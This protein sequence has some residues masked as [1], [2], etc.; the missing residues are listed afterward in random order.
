[1]NGAELP[2]RLEVVDSHTEGEPTRVIAGGW[3]ELA[4]ATMAERRDELR[5]HHDAL[6][7]SVVC[8]PRGHEAVVG[9]LLTPPV[10]PGS[11]AGVIFFDNAGYL[12]M[13]GHG[14]IGVVRTLE[15]L[16]RLDPAPPGTEVQTLRLDTPVG[17]VTAEIP[18]AGGA[19]AV[20]SKGA[21]GALGDVEVRDGWDRDEGAVTV[22]NVP[23][24][25]HAVDVTVEV[26]WLGR[27]TGDVA[28]GGNWFF[29]TGIGQLGGVPLV[30]DQVGA[31]IAATQRIR[32]AL[33]AAGVTGDDGAEIDH[34]EVFGPP[35]GPWANSRN[36]VLCPGG[37]YD[38]SP[39]GTG[40]SAK[41]AVLHARGELALGQ[42]WRQ[43]SITG[44]LFS[45]WLSSAGD[46]LVPHI[47][48]RAFVTGRTTL[49]FDPRDPFRGG[50]PSS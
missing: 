31:L 50:F 17:T 24:R 7:R 12:G 19:R 34:I 26:P 41:L 40:T 44:G 49:L 23:A 37:A 25:C 33:A 18:A 1:M 42:R 15:F 21:M 35:S 3:V 20:G 48:G 47:R 6:R 45:A 27:V 29:M 11:I 10:E 46:Q 32:E 16:G 13:C 28:Y 5:R 4:G 2:D 43:E 22:I 36:F 14:T 39:C 8:E 30:R 38:R 9:A